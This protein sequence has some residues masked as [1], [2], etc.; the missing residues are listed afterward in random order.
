MAKT[1]RDIIAVRLQNAALDD[2]DKDTIVAHGW[3]DLSALLEL[4][5]GDYQREV[6]ETHKSKKSKLF[7]AIENGERI[8]DITLGMRGQRFTTRAGTFY[9]EDDVYIIDGLQRV[10][11][12]RKFAVQY[13]DRIDEIRIGAEVRFNTTRESEK[14]LFTAMNLNRT[15]MSPNVILRNAREE[16]NG[17]LTLFGLSHNDP[18][19]VLYNRVCWNQKMSRNELLTALNYCKSAIALHRGIT[20]AGPTTSVTFIPPLLARVADE[21]S[22]QVTRDNIYRFYEVI[23]EVWGIKGVKYVDLTTHLR[24]NFLNMVAKLFTLHENFWDRTRLVIDAKQRQKL[25]SFPITD[26]SIQKLSAGG[27][28]AADLLYRLMVDHMNKGQKINRLIE[29]SSLPSA[30]SAGRKE[31]MEKRGVNQ[32]RENGKFVPMKKKSEKA[33]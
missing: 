9:L 7:T 14:A 32:A 31:D 28:A 18:S 13:P 27:G 2:K 21:I 6:L 11:N 8:P 5:V 30:R 26:P 4:R 3:L 25:K 10:S 17:L 33:A 22:I 1:E 29:R 15:A 16:S 23:D 24:A 12:L 20:A 19:F